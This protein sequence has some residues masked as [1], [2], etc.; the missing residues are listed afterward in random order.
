MSQNG[1]D[2]QILSMK[3]S[4]LTYVTIESIWSSEVNISWKSVFPGSSY[5]EEHHNNNTEYSRSNNLKYFVSS[6]FFLE[7]SPNGA[8]RISTSSNDAKTFAETNEFESCSS[9]SQQGGSLYFGEKGELVQ[10]KN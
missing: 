6:C 9:G 3:N 4:T 1:L 2:K 10:T 8:V 5:D 7:L